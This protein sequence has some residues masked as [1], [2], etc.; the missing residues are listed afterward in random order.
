L[1]GLGGVFGPAVKRCSTVGAVKMDGEV[2]VAMVFE[3]NYG[4]SAL[5]HPESGTWRYAIV[6]DK[7][8][9]LQTLVNL[10]FERLHIN[11]VEVDFVSCC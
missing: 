2:F 9:W 10:M 7:P 3:S 4:F 11:F 8:S 5:S 6:S 1:T